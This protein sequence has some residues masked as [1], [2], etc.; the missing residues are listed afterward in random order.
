MFSKSPY[1]LNVTQK[2]NQRTTL[3]IEVQQAGLFKL[4]KTEEKALGYL[5]NVYCPNL[6]YP[7][8]AKVVSGLSIDAG[9]PPVVLIPMNF[10]A[11]YRQQKENPSEAQQA[12]L[13]KGTAQEET[14]AHSVFIGLLPP[15]RE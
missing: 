12:E 10:E 4:G 14:A 2:I 7:Y 8:A 11:M 1:T 9:L 13:S 6:L 15:L 5:L 3:T